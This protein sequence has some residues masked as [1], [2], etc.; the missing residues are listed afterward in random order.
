MDPFIPLFRINL[1]TVE[2]GKSP[3]SDIKADFI[4]ET[5]SES[6][7]DGENH[8]I[9]VRFSQSCHLFPISPVMFPVTPKHS[10]RTLF[11]FDSS[12]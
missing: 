10:L 4:S 2:F 7:P 11:T 1:N 3:I 5:L 6:I 12:I 9:C 8:V